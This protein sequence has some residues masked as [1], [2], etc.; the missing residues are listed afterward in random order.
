M[1][2]CQSKIMYACQTFIFEFGF[3]FFW[4]KVLANNL[5]MFYEVCVSRE[6]GSNF[7]YCI[8]NGF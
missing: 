4:L 7:N 6:R 3:K 2:I 1:Y 5:W 8:S